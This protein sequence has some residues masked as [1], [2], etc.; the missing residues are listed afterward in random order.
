MH[1]PLF[2]RRESL[3]P[4]GLHFNTAANDD[5]FKLIYAEFEKLGLGVEM[6][7]VKKAFGNSS[8]KSNLPPVLPWHDV[9]AEQGS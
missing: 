8:T 3:L 2:E 4:D 1:T 6:D 7:P 9:L 5:V